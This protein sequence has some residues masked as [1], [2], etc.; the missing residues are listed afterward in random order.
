[1]SIVDWIS[2]AIACF[3]GAASPGPSILIIVYHSSTKGA[4]K[5]II[6]SIGHG[7]GIFIY[8]LLTALGV[9]Y[10]FESFPQ[11]LFLIKI[12]GIL[13][14]FFISVQMFLYKETYDQKLSKIDL[15]NYNSLTLG[16]L[17]AL[18]NPKVIL[19]FGA[20]FSQFLKPELDLENKLLISCLASLID[21]IWYILV[22]FLSTLT[23]SRY[24]IK[25]KQITV[26]CLGIILFTVTIIMIMKIFN[27]NINF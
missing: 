6:C 14:L 22:V 11:I 5:G 3:V 26:K 8:A 20:I 15:Q 9:K 19:F 1:M 13:F 4:F 7:I 27:L 17:T 16:I 21:A 24:L 12:L 2:I 23:I 18:I 25:Y 10:F